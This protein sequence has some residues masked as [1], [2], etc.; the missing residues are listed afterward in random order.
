VSAVA[1]DAK[2]VSVRR[3]VGPLACCPRIGR[4]RREKSQREAG[5]TASRL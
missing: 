5:P 2:R 4:R 3:I 1:V